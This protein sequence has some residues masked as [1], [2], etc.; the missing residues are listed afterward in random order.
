MSRTPET[1]CGEIRILVYWAPEFSLKK[2]RGKKKR[3]KE[4]TFKTGQKASKS[5]ENRTFCGNSENRALPLPLT[6]KTS[7]GNFLQLQLRLIHQPAM[8]FP[9][10]FGCTT[11]IPS[12]SSLQVSRPFPFHSDDLGF[13]FIYPPY[14][15]ESSG[16]SL[17]C[18]LRTEEDQLAP[19]ISLSTFP[20]LEGSGASR[21]QHSPLEVSRPNHPPGQVQADNGDSDSRKKLHLP[22]FLLQP[23]V[24]RCCSKFRKEK[25][26]QPLDLCLHLLYI[27]DL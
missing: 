7:S 17:S 6:G 23:S 9:R 22:L 21:K 18:H 8:I 12:F 19:C 26:P 25:F 13:D 14:E 15:V 10:N 4:F 11:S 16:S 27:I 24:Q 1:V 2:K 5:P 20:R 3:K